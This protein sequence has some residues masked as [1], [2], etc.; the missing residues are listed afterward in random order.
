MRTGAKPRGLSKHLWMNDDQK[1]KWWKKRKNR[2][3][4]V[5]ISRRKNRG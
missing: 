1:A 4:M 2:Q 3:R 5:R